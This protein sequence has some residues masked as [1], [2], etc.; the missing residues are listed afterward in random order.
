MWID[1]EWPQIE[2]SREEYDEKLNALKR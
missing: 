2:K 1:A